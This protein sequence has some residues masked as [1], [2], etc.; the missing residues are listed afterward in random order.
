MRESA[1][2]TCQ[3]NCVLM[4]RL[5]ADKTAEK[6]RIPAEMQEKPPFVHVL[7]SLTGPTAH[8]GLSVPAKAAF[9]HPEEKYALLRVLGIFRPPQVLG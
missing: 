1:Q 3:G 6:N 9:S 8:I 2:N 5:A 7:G 4:R